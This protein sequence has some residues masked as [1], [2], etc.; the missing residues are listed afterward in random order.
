[1]HLPQLVFFLFE[2]AL[3]EPHESVGLELGAFGVELAVGVVFGFAVE[4]DH[5]FDS[6]LFPF[7]PWMLGL[8]LL[9]R[10]C[11]GSMHASR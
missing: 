8:G 6:F 2:G 10:H 5:G 4:V 9:N 11:E 3:I 1:V 7:H